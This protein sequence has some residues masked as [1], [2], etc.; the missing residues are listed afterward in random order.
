MPYFLLAPFR[1]RHVLQFVEKNR[2]HRRL[3]VECSLAA[4][5]LS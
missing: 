4:T 1:E 3:H 2:K 5:E